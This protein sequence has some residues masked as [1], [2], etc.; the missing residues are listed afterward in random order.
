VAIGLLRKLGL[1]ADG[2]ADGLEAIEAL[3]RVPYDL[4]LMDVQMP[5]MDGLE[6]TRTVRRGDEPTLCPSV[7]IIAMTAHG[8]KGDRERCLDA[9]MDDY[10]VKPVSVTSLARVLDRWLAV[11]DAG[12]LRP[13]AAAA[14]AFQVPDTD[15]EEPASFVLDEAGLLDR[16]M[17]DR[18]LATRLLRGFLADIPKQ[19]DAMR[20]S[21]NAGDV[22]ATSRQ[23]H[24]MKGAAAA[25]GGDHVARLASLMEQQ[26]GAGDALPLRARFAELEKEVARLTGAIRTWTGLETAMEARGCRP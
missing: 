13:A 11:A 9:G 17:G 6:A 4:V 12:S 2:V 22:K 26:G 14:R 15:S 20:G 1:R 18:E 23:A 8:M 10:V 3:R 19:M 21:I 16:L 5:E 25:V 24:K 7:P